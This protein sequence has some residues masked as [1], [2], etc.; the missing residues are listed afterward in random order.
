M[1]ENQKN[2]SGE[3][4]FIELIKQKLPKYSKKSNIH[5]GIGDDCAVV[6]HTQGQY[7]YTTDAMVEGVHFRLDWSSITDVVYKAVVANLSDVNAMGGVPHSMLVTVGIPRTWSSDQKEELAYAIASAATFYE[8]PV[9]GGDTVSSHTAFLSISMT[10]IVEGSLLLRSSALPGHSIYVSGSLGDSAAGLDLLQSG[11]NDN[12]WDALVMAHCRPSFPS[13]LGKSLSQ[14]KVAVGCMDISDGLSSE[15]NHISV[16]S[17]VKM[18]VYED[19]IPISSHLSQF[20]QKGSESCRKY[21]LN[22]GEEY[23][24]LFTIDESANG[25]REL[26]QQYSLTKIGE[27]LQGTGVLLVDHSGKEQEVSSNAFTHF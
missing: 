1:N 4:A 18:R 27:V 15:L 2:Q 10:G 20:S 5:L 22:G 3:F 14:L 11:I 21:W 25:F 13:R 7:V 19:L 26:V 8:V 16:K 23:Q 12:I 9:I 17:E 6:T 24:L